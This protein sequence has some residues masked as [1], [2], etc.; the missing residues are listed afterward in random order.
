[1]ETEISSYLF[2]SHQKWSKGIYPV[3]RLFPHA[4]D[5]NFETAIL[6]KIVQNSNYYKLGGWE[7][8]HNTLGKNYNLCKL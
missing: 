5:K 8:L 1:M 3:L 2:K 6:F 4:S 7:F